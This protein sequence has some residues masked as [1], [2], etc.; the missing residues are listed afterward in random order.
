ME[1]I[2]LRA[3]SKHVA[4]KVP[5]QMARRRYGRAVQADYLAHLHAIAILI[6]TL[7][8]R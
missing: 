1:V 7:A 5:N 3:S 8:P 2:G 6:V 4:F